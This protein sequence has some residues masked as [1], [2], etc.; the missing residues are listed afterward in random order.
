MTPI[1]L[2][3]LQW[4]SSRASRRSLLRMNF[5]A[6]SCFDRIIASITSLAAR[7]YGQHQALCFIHG[8]FLQQENTCSKQNLVYRTRN[9]PAA[10]CIQFMAQAKVVPTAPL[11]VTRL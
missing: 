6:S 2:E 8:T 4:E 11:S 3:E 9:I 10:A 5:D 7:S 1:F